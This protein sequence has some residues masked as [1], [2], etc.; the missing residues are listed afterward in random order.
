MRR[1]VWVIPLLLVI[2]W[3]IG[4]L[5]SLEISQQQGLLESL[6]QQ[7]SLSRLEVV[8]QRMNT[9]YRDLLF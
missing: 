3:L 1:F 7:F 5:Y 9:V 2:L 8:R 4:H 6:E